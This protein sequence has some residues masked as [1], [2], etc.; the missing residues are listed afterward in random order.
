MSSFFLGLPPCFDGVHP[1]VT[2]WEHKNMRGK[3]FEPFRVLKCADLLL[4][5]DRSCLLGR[6]G[7]KLNGNFFLGKSEEKVGLHATGAAGA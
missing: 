4:T 1:A 6:E 3:I 5:L 2:F 7:Q